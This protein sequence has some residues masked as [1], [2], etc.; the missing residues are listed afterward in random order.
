MS[1]TLAWAHI[2]RTSHVV[3]AP[4]STSPN[5]CV[6]PAD[7]AETAALTLTTPHNHT[8]QAYTLTGPQALSPTDQTTQLAQLLG[9]PIHCEELTPQQAHTALRTRYPPDITTALLES[10]THQHTSPK[11]HINPTLPRL[12]HHPARTF[13]NWATNHLH[14]FRPGAATNE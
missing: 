2:I 3:R 12:L 11:T 7:I 8:H 14:R 5:A 9:H 1:N 10:A 4:Y 6:H 13:R